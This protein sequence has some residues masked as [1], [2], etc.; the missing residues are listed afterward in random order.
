MKQALEQER[1]KPDPPEANLWR[2]V[3]GQAI[4]DLSQP[5]LQQ[6]AVE[7]LASTAHGPG[8]FRWAC[9]HLDLNPAAVWAALNHANVL[10]RTHS[11]LG[12]CSARRR[13]LVIIRVNGG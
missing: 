10:D 2:A 1:I 4:D 3:I 12:S 11:S 9:D 8:S 6:A 13:P 5:A 7:W